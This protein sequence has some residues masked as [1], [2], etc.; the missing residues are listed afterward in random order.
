MALYG[1]TPHTKEYLVWLVADSVQKQ[2]SCTLIQTKVR[3]VLTR[4]LAA[5]AAAEATMSLISKPNIG[6]GPVT[7]TSDP[8]RSPEDPP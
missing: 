4:T 7:F 5:A 8:D 1:H 2:G 6:P 3:I